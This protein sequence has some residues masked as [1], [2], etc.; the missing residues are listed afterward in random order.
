MN[1]ID[2]SNSN[3]SI[4]SH[5]LDIYAIDRI[6]NTSN[7]ISMNIVK[8][9]VFN[10]KDY[11]AKGDG[12]TDDTQAVRNTIEEAKSYSD[13]NIITVIYFPTGVYLIKQFKIHSNMY[14]IGDGINRTK[15]IRFV[16]RSRSS[17]YDSGTF[18]TRTDPPQ[19]HAGD[20]SWFKS[21]ITNYD[22]R[23]NRT[24]PINSYTNY[25]IGV[26]NMTIN[27]NG[28][29]FNLDGDENRNNMLLKFK[30]CKNIIIDNVRLE[31]S[32]N[33]SLDLRESK[34]INIGYLEIEGN[35]QRD[36]G[37][38]ND[39]NNQDGINMHGVNNAVIDR[40]IVYESYD[41]SMFIGAAIVGPS[42]R[43]DLWVPNPAFNITVNYLEVYRQVG[44]G[45]ALAIT[46]EYLEGCDVYN[47]HIKHV[48]LHN[49]G[50]RGMIIMH[51]PN[52][53][54]T[55]KGEG[56]GIIHD[57]QIDKIESYGYSK[58]T[59]M[60]HPMP[61]LRITSRP[62]IPY[63]ETGKYNN[64]KFYNIHIKDIYA[65][66]QQPLYS[67]DDPTTNKQVGIILENV[68]HVI[69]DNATLINKNNQRYIFDFVMSSDI[70][71][72]NSYIKNNQ[73]GGWSL[74]RMKDTQDVTIYTTIPYISGTTRQGGAALRVEGDSRNITVYYRELQTS[75]T[76]SFADVPLENR[77]TIRLIQI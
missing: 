55:P 27:G 52:Y 17:L 63:A 13:N 34:Y 73:S 11:N 32:M 59:L 3:I 44:T 10:V 51:Y 19:E 74:M 66:F 72:N 7:A 6:G 75:S 69:I 77:D 4:G 60:D 58:G 16:D 65:D 1:K 56:R 29:S 48:K 37:R 15:L 68:Q 5:T 26:K 33:W 49:L 22:F 45:H 39:R 2:I 62:S 31:D 18:T 71:V 61:L 38:V 23:G 9:K 41:D 24:D 76:V 35:T 21:F 14:L 42:D 70:T 47:V 57:I 67:S 20:D 30:R 40:V 50:Q 8:P 64:K 36:N 53:A 46:S 12:I 25:N 28:Y 54:E 43:P